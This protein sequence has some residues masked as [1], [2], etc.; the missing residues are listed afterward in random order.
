M[1]VKPVNSRLTKAEWEILRERLKTEKGVLK[2][3]EKQYQAALGEIETRIAILLGRGDA[4]LPHVI[5]RI[6]YQRMI[7]AQVKAALDK[8]QANEY[9]TITAYLEDCYT[10][11][12]VGTAYSLHRQG[13]P[14]II[15]INQAAAVKAVTIDS[16][17]KAPLYES[18]GVDVTKLKKTIAEEITR[19]IASGTSY[20]EI[21]TA[22]HF[23]TGAPLSRAMTITRTEAGR[24]TEQAAFDAANQAKAAGAD[25]VKQWSAILDGKTRD[26]HRQLDHQ[27]RELDEPFAIGGKKAMHP[28]GFGDPAE[29]CNCRC[30][31]LTRARSAMDEDELKTMQERAVFFG[32][33]KTDSFEDFKKKY[34]KAVQTVDNTGKSG[35]IKT[36]AIH[37]SLGAAAKNYPVKL[38]DSKQHVKLAEGQ[39]LTGKTFAG[40]GTETKIKDRFRLES[41]YHVPA[42]KWEKVSA[43]GYI[44]VGGKKRKAELHWYE[45]DGE[46][47]EMKVKRFLDDEG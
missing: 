9:E 38:A 42:E 24:V 35:I 17:L 15:P 31:M 2:E 44:V 10:D 21:S 45:A 6:E 16:K 41:T 1:T 34:L 46:V 28:H 14:L 39:T 3:L 20:Q 37:K 19:G 32:L 11:G 5:R 36:V 22:I 12:V 26:T 30:T 7:R 18:L 13:M 29:D 25:V 40:K 43:P 4:D 8:L 33:D 27:V 23:V 47:Y